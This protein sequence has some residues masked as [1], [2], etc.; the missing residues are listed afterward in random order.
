MLARQVDDLESFTSLILQ[1]LGQLISA[2]FVTLHIEDCRR[3]CRIIHATLSRE[4]KRWKFTVDDTDLDYRK[5]HLQRFNQRYLFHAG[6]CFPLDLSH[7]W[8]GTFLVGYPGIKILSSRQYRILRNILQDLSDSLDIVLLNRELKVLERQAKEKELTNQEL[9]QTVTDLSKEAYCVSSVIT[10]LTQSLDV[11]KV[12]TRILGNTL[13]LLKARSGYVYFPETDQCISL[14]SAGSRYQYSK[15]GHSLGHQ[16]SKGPCLKNYFENKF[17]QLETYCDGVSFN[18]ISIDDPSLSS[19]FKERFN[20]LGIKSVF[21][22]SLCSGDECLGLGLIGF[23]EKYVP[24]DRS[25]LFMITLNMTN[26]F[27]E[28]ISLMRDLE[29]QV[30]RKSKKILGME[31]EQRFLFDH[32]TLP[33]SFS[34]A[35]IQVPSER[36]LE[37]IDRSRKALFLGELA[38]GVA[39]QIRNPLNNL[40]AVLHLLKNTDGTGEGDSGPLLEQVT[41]RVETIHRMINKFIHYTRIPELNLTSESINKVLKDTI[42][43]FKGWTDL[44]KVEVITSFDPDLSLTKFDLYLMDQVYRNIIKNALEAMYSNGQL[45]ISTRKLGIKHGPNPRLEFAE[46]SFQD[47]GPGIPE[48]DIKKILNPF[49][50]RKKDGIGLGLAIVD[51]VVGLHGGGVRIE[52]RAGKGANVMIYLPIR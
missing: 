7:R 51:H 40:V 33:F 15:H 27:L 23:P 13:P 36:I 22:F 28:N 43:A 47:S 48:E 5:S 18:L 34:K 19:Y 38:S 52:N 14:Q 24:A 35:G 44:A 10:G 41:E 6:F 16:L 32:G 12:F 37:E 39:H 25:R 2:R 26:L 31:K 49:F 21:E 9:R 4:C 30:K 11:V 1:R 29:R 17:S 45:S 8:S 46:I 3:H 20:S 50:S 42:Q